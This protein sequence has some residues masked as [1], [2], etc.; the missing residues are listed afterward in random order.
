MDFLNGSVENNSGCLAPPTLMELTKEK[1]H[2]EAVE[3]C[4]QR[5]VVVK[6]AV[7]KLLAYIDAHPENPVFLSTSQRR[8][9]TL[10]PLTPLQRNRTS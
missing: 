7:A 10:I 4:R 8:V 2:L 1:A 5:A 9:E 6:E 3:A